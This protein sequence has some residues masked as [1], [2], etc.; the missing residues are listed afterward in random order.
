MNQRRGM[1]FPKPSKAISG[2]LIGVFALWLIFAV[3]VNWLGV[4]G[5][6][7]GALIGDSQAVAQGQIWRLLT[8]GLLHAPNDVVHM[9]VT[10]MLVYFF[11]P[12]LEERWGT[13]RLFLFLAGSTVFAF[14]VEALLFQI[15]P[16]V[17]SRSW[18]GGMA[19]ADAAL[20]AWALGARGQ[21]VNLYFVI[22]V[23]PMMMVGLMVAWH[24]L[25]LVARTPGVEGAF[26]PFA[27]MLAGWLLHDTSP[28]R[29]LYLKLK[30]RRLQREVSGMTGAKRK[31]RKT[32]PKLFVIDGGRKDDDD[33]PM[34]H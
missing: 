2:L 24:M 26:A 5:D 27:A 3:A 14:G 13:K 34:L 29:R 21:T 11:A 1:R 8:A 9:L 23:K 30:L 16:T 7:F 28:L 12:P 6:L 22:P 33:D 32:G 15:I 18:L 10:L 25:T 31:A 4:G 20:V 19:M 17:A